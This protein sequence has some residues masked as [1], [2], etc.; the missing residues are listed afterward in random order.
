MRACPLHSHVGHS[1]TSTRMGVQA[2]H[3]SSKKARR[4]GVLRLR[5]ISLPYRWC[6]LPSLC[7]VVTSR[8]HVWHVTESAD[9]EG[10]I[11]SAVAAV[12]RAKK[13]CCR[14]HERSHQ[15]TLVMELAEGEK[16]LQGLR[17]DAHAKALVWKTSRLGGRRFP[18]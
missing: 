7:Q 13:T 16:H 12:H 11:E 18:D 5:L 3:V 15:T 2:S 1:W 14:D 6:V 9:K 10:W 4:T 8:S 17:R